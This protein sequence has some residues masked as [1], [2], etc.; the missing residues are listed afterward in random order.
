MMDTSTIRLPALDIDDVWHKPT[1][2]GTSIEFC[3]EHDGSGTWDI[4]VDIQVQ[5]GDQ[6]EWFISDIRTVQLV[7][8]MIND[9]P[10]HRRRHTEVIGPLKD[11]LVTFLQATEAMKLQHHVDLEY[12]PT[13]LG[14]YIDQRREAA[15]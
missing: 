11:Q 8:Y 3:Y 12:L 5:G 10:H 13:S 15:I 2:D 6:S 14:L 7:R 9:K 4:E 1:A